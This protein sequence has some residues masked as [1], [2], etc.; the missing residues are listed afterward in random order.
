ML[1]TGC[2]SSSNN[3]TQK[4]SISTQFATQTTDKEARYIDVASDLKKDIN[5]L[6]GTMN[7]AP[8]ELKAG[9]TLPAVF[10]RVGS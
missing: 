10:D 1:L 8:V 9:E 4:Q 3:T 5:T 6:F 2:G 7:D